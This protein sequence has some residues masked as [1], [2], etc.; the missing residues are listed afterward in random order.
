MDIEFDYK[1]DPVGGV[2]STCKQ[3]S[4]EYEIFYLFFFNFR[5][6]RKGIIIILL[7]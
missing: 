7:I 6:A 1:G 4:C 2:I 5:L 3:W